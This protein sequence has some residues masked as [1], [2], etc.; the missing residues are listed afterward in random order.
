MSELIF[1]GK[2]PSSEEFR[3]MLA[4]AIAAA[5][6]VDDL[7]ELGNR[8]YAYEQKYQMPSAAFYQ[9]YQAGTLDEELQHCTEWAAIYDL[10]VKTQ[11]GRGQ[12]QRQVE[13]TT[14]LKGELQ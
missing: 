14:L 9:R 13:R 7:L 3:Q 12:S 10:F 11:T 4:Q 1:R 6:P 5:N 8:L 2:L